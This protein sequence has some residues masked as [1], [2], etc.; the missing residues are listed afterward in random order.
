MNIKLAKRHY[1]VQVA[2][3]TIDTV[4]VTS[5]SKQHV[6]VHMLVL[7]QRFSTLKDR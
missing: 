5:P 3:I 6:T 4:T 1:I 7:I 2:T